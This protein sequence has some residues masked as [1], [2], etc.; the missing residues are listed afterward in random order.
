MVIIEIKNTY[1]TTITKLI[2]NIMKLQKKITMILN[3]N[4][5]GDGDRWI[6]EQNK[7]LKVW[8]MHGL[9]KHK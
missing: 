6:K 2:I 4:N 8:I 1:I 7:P 5:D 3:N 9:G